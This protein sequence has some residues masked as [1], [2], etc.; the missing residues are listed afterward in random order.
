[1]NV[2]EDF[3][4][5]NELSQEAQQACNV[6]IGRM[7]STLTQ[8]S[9]GG[10][11]AFHDPK[12]WN[13]RLTEN[14]DGYIGDPVLIVCHDGGDQARFFNYDYCDYDAVNSMMDSLNEIGLYSE[15][16]TSWYSAIY[17]S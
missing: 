15:Q 13:D 7:L 3:I 2:N 1:M 8:I 10:C 4:I 17:R 16:I 12:S 11:K 14:P 9:G 5:D 6:I